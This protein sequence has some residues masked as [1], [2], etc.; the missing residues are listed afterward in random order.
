M[1]TVNQTM[2]FSGNVYAKSADGVLCNFDWERGWRAESLKDEKEFLNKFIGQTLEV[3]FEQPSHGRKGYF[4]GK[5][6]NYITVTVPADE[7]KLIEKNV[8]QYFMVNEEI[9]QNN[10]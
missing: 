2:V 9:L 1:A 4:E 3:L 6:D 5:T 8:Y 7:M 10:L